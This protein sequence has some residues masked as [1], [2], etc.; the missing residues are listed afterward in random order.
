MQPVS[1]AYPPVAPSGLEYDLRWSGLLTQLDGQL[2]RRDRV[3]GGAGDRWG[4]LG[5]R[6]RG[7]IDPRVLGPEPGRREPGVAV[8]AGL[9]V[10]FRVVAENTVGDTFDYANPATTTRSP[11]FPG[12]TGFPHVTVTSESEILLVGEPPPAAPAGLTA[13]LDTTVPAGRF[14]LDRQCGRRNPAT[15]SN[16]PTTR[17]F[18]RSRPFRPTPCASPIRACRPGTSTS[19]RLL[20]GTPAVISGYSNPA[21]VDWTGAAPAAPT[22]LAA[23][24]ASATQV[25]LTW[26]EIAINETGFVVERSDNGGAFA[27]IAALTADSHLRPPTV[28][29]PTAT[30]TRWP[31]G[32]SPASPATRTRRARAS[33]SRPPPST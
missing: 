15:L 19:T 20:P 17:R 2:D 1:V 30:P 21:T 10:Q 33:R 4:H 12:D 26:T 14:G 18:R 22:S 31:R 9:G 16:G 23:A 27:V 32:M 8:G 11:A 3:L 28:A 6:S 7:R 13:T 5:S 25:D 24:G 29:A